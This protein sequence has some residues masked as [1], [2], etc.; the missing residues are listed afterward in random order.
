MPR[1]VHSTTS[2][3][4]FIPFVQ[5]DPLQHF[6]MPVNWFRSLV[7]WNEQVVESLP[8]SPLPILILQGTH[9]TVVD[10]TYNL[11]FLQDKFFNAQVQLIHGARHDLFWE[12]ASLREEIFTRITAFLAELPSKSKSDLY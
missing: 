9:D 5:K 1:W 4:E 6:A 11:P 7:R 2:D 10:R 12:G 8:R 3:P